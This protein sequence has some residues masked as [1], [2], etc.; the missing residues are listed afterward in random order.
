MAEDFDLTLFEPS[1]SDMLKDYPELKAFSEFDSLT[2]REV[3]LCWYLGNSTSPL[4]KGKLKGRDKVDAA[5]T[6]CYDERAREYDKT[7]QA[8]LSMDPP[9]KIVAGVSR[10]KSFTPSY[11]LQAKWMDEYIFSMLNGLVVL[12]GDEELAMKLDP[13]TKKKYVDLSIKVS[14]EMP[15]LIARMESGYGVKLVKKNQTG[16]ILTGLSEHTDRLRD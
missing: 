15:D 13:D 2:V 5:V 3:K 4:A 11:R 8:V 6:A 1:G 9:A 16:V 10:F 14:S 7:V 12:G